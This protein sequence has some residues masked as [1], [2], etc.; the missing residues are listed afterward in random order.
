MLK[1]RFQY[2]VFC[3][4]YGV[5]SQFTPESGYR[6]LSDFGP[7]PKAVYPVGR[8]DVDSEG[9]LLLTNDNVVKHAL[10]NPHSGHPK[11][12]LAQ[13]ER[14]P[15]PESLRKLRRGVLL[16]GRMTLPADVRLW[17]D[18]PD[19]P[20]RSVPIRYRKNVPT[21]WLEIVLR[22]GRNRQVRRMTAAIGHPTLRLIRTQVATLSLGNLQP[23]QHRNLATSEVLDLKRLLEVG[24]SG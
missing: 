2:V 20:P 24:G 18:E 16:K 3:K 6:S 21:C 14:V 5:L 4:P 17:M 1:E 11:T 8:L 22:E 9:L 23:G 10:T 19:L 7:F 13:V 15:L 12:Y